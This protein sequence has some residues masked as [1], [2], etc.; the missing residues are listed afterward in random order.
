MVTDAFILRLLIHAAWHTKQTTVLVPLQ[1]HRQHT[2]DGSQ[3]QSSKSN[4]FEVHYKV[5]NSNAYCLNKALVRGSEQSITA[6]FR[7]M[8]VQG[9]ECA[10]ATFMRVSAHD[11][12]SA[13][14]TCSIR[15]SILV[16]AISVETSIML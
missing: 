14:V 6:S 2:T 16:H 3:H 9:L 10:E 13:P 12:A 11:L 7:Q 5:G 15:P 1:T 8:V 4:F